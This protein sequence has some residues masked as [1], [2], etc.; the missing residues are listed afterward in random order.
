MKNI[1]YNFTY[2]LSFIFFVSI[3]ICCEDHNRKIV[4]G[5][6]GNHNNFSVEFNFYDNKTDL[7]AWAS[8]EGLDLDF[9]PGLAKMALRVVGLKE[10]DLKECSAS[11]FCNFG[12]GDI[13]IKAGF[14][15]SEGLQEELEERLYTKGGEF[16]S[17]WA[18][19]SKEEKAYVEKRRQEM[20]DEYYQS[21]GLVDNNRKTL[22]KG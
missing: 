8:P 20:R 5:W 18:S 12:D 9:I 17:F 19:L 13:R 2:L 15:P 21:R 1:N 10:K 11:V 7:C 14:Y 22:L 6:V 3:N 16:E 4:G